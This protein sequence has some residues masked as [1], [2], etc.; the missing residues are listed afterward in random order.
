[1]IV[2]TRVRNKQRQ[3]VT[4]QPWATDEVSTRNCY[5]CLAPRAGTYVSCRKGHQMTTSSERHRRNLTYNGVVK[6]GRLMKPC[7][8][9][10]DFDN[11]W[12]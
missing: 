11:D 5:H 2:A 3:V 12:D 9:C 10:A 6:L 8:N 1:V 4:V 7:I